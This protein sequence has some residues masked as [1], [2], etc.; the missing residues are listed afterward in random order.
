LR[1]IPILILTTFAL[2]TVLI[3]QADKI[4]HGAE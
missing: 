4:R 3:R 2:R 1:L